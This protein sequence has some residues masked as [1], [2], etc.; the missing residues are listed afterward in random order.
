VGGVEDSGDAGGEGGGG[1]CGVGEAHGAGGA[2]RARKLAGL[3]VDRSDFLGTDFERGGERIVGVA[4]RSV[5]FSVGPKLGDALCHGLLFPS[6]CSS[7]EIRLEIR[8]ELQSW[9]KRV[10][11]VVEASLD[12]HL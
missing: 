12:K 1:K 10:P 9:Q 4:V 5:R 2:A 7:L 3:A 11:I 8:V 6:V